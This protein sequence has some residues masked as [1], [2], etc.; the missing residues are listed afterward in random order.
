LEHR[1]DL[2]EP[3][4]K[5][6]SPPSAAIVAFSADGRWLVGAGPMW[7]RGWRSYGVIKAWS[8]TRATQLTS[9][10]V[11]RPVRR[12]ALADD[13]SVV[14]VAASY[15]YPDSLGFSPPR[16][17]TQLAVYELP[18]GKL[19]GRYPKEIDEIPNNGIEGLA[20]VLAARIPA[21][22]TKVHVLCDDGFCF[23]WDFVFRR[24]GVGFFADQRTDG[25]AG[26]LHSA[27]FS[28]DAKTL[29]TAGPGKLCVWNTESQTLEHME[30]VPLANQSLQ[31]A[32]SPDGERLVGAEAAIDDRQN[33]IRIW[34]IPSRKL[35]FTWPVPRACATCFAFSPDNAKLLTGLDRGTAEI[36]D[37][38]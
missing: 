18:S 34:D 21:G 22:S 29:F 5:Y 20:G 12:M 9:I 8:T 35:Q 27:V 24:L 26:E 6:L 16:R 13:G 33:N 1:L 36:W 11:D 32:I 25:R 3:G 2:G 10:E 37:A 28:P 15:G 30:V 31:L 38:Q 4:V 14:A 17:N 19:L 23:H 7:S